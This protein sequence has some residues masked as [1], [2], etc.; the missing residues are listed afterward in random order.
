M[1]LYGYAVIITLILA[2]CGGGITAFESGGDYDSMIE[3]GWQRYNQ[4]LFEEA[5]DLF[6]AA[7]SFDDTRPEAYLGCGWSLFMRQ[8]P[9]SALVVFFQGFNYYTSF[10]DTVDASCGISGSY[11]ARKE[12]TKVITFL[13]QYDLSLFDA[14][15]PLR[16]HDFFLERGDLELVYA[17]AYYRLGLFSSSESSDP[18]NSLFHFNQVQLMP[19]TYTTPEELMEKMTEYL[20]QSEGGFYK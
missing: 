8:K 3:S 19:Y 15:F 10:E 18:D 4:N 17:Q 16:D 5:Q 11:L 6:C 13:N 12:N 7:K 20:Y 2:G 14:V 1:K 9:D